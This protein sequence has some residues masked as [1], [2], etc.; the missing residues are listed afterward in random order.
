M[1]TWVGKV[2]DDIFSSFNTN[3]LKDTGHQPRRLRIASRSK[4]RWR[5]WR[6]RWCYI[7][8]LYNARGKLSS[9]TAICD[10]DQKYS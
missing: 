1:V 9:Y 8:Y 4:T 7:L 6:W 2:S 3:G 5:I 10:N